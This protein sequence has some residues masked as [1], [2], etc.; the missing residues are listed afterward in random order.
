MINNTESGKR[1]IHD[2]LFTQFEAD[3]ESGYNDLGTQPYVDA[4]NKQSLKRDDVEEQMLSLNTLQIID[5]CASYF[6][7]LNIMCKCAYPRSVYLRFMENK[8]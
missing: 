1:F 3:C 2:L 8:L 5:S 7:G 4:K 6:N